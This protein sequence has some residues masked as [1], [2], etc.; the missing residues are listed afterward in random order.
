V[1]NAAS[2]SRSLFTQQTNSPTETHGANSF[3]QLKTVRRIEVRHRKKPCDLR[4]PLR[5][6]VTPP[7]RPLVGQ[8][9]SDQYI[10]ITG[11]PGLRP[12]C[13][14]NLAVP[15]PAALAQIS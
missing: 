15:S 14:S 2:V 10:P 11:N 12:P 5:L 13:Y 9:A 8:L 4:E 1:N 7:I 6:A 3:E